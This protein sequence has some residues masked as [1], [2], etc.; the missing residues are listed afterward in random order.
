MNLSHPFLI[1]LGCVAPFGYVIAGPEGF[2][3]KSG[4]A[5]APLTHADGSMVIQSGDHAVIEWESFSIDSGET[6]RFQQAGVESSVLNCV[7][8]STESQIF[9]QLFSN[10]A[11]YLVNP[12][13]IL[14]G[15]EAYIE[16]AGFIAS[17]LPCMP[18]QEGNLQ[19]HGESD[20]GIV[21]QGVIHCAVGDI[22]LI[23]RIVDNQGTLISPEGRQ[24]LLSASDIVLFPKGA[25]RIHIRSDQ[26]L[27]EE[28]LQ[29]NPYAFAIRHRG[30]IEAQEAYLVSEE[31]VSE[32]S[33]TIVAAF[34]EGSGG[35]VQ[36]LG[37]RVHVL[38]GAMIDV[39]GKTGGGAILLGGDYQ[40]KNSDVKNAKLTWVGK[41]T[42][43][44]A[45]AKQKGDGGKVILWAD[46]ATFHYGSISVRGG[47]EGGNGGFVEI[48][49]PTLEPRGFVD[50][51]APH[52]TAGTLL[53]DPN[54][55]VIG[56]S[57]TTGTWSSC[58]P[59]ISYQFV[60]G[61]VTNQI[62]NTDLQMQLGKLQCDHQHSWDKW[63]GSQQRI[64]HSFKRSDMGRIQYN[65]CAH[66][67][68]SQLSHD[69]QHD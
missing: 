54:D 27:D 61:T 38:D 35:A 10:G 19:F 58:V 14:I 4:A 42:R 31:G 50:A 60:S 66:V 49:A 40:G 30:K 9:G 5:E 28:T 51:L 67:N 29:E 20:K 22:F 57:S 48:S 24:G 32:V 13:G 12:N 44:L 26:P 6:V 11:V 15:K 34:E 56:G 23:G 18:D 69:Q 33:G 46:R 7:I 16:T 63:I 52:G 68:R 39:S 3:L 41:E 21:N 1:I 65:Q 45:D 43:I 64:N 36:V 55:V 59:P 47:D 62:L 2:V 8:G 37:D 25:P 53:L 17:T